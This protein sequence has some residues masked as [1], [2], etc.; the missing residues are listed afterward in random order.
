M[1]SVLLIDDDAAERELVN[2]CLRRHFGT[3]YELEHV[4]Q[5]EPALA[6][7]RD[8]Q[9][10]AILLDNVIPP[11]KGVHESLPL[12]RHAAPEVKIVAI[13]TTMDPDRRAQVAMQDNVVIV[14]KFE[15]KQRIAD[16]LLD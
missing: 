6:R 7:L 1:I 12:V 3:G 10:D 8:R 15:L 14:N 4:T 9:F 16:G 2:F 11:F 5:V 13:S